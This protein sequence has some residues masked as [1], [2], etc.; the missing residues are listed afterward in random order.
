MQNNE[1][2]INKLTRKSR[3]ST[4]LA[5]ANKKEL[6]LNNSEDSEKKKE[7]KSGASKQKGNVF[8]F[9]FKNRK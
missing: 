3:S 4:N 7:K 6:G 5:T 8:K 1:S 9:L 2:E